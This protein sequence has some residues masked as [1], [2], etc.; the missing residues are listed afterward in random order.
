[1]ERMIISTLT[2]G[3]ELYGDSPLILWLFNTWRSI[4]NSFHSWKIDQ[5]DKR[6]Q[7]VIGFFKLLIAIS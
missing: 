3:Y 5:F 4:G 6:A 7:H 2:S 1:M